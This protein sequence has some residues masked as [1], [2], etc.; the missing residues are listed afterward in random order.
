MRCGD[1]KLYVTV[2][3]YADGGMGEIFVNAHREGQEMRTMLGALA[4]MISQALQH[5]RD[6]AKIAEALNSFPYSPYLTIISF[7]LNNPHF[8][9]VREGGETIV[10]DRH[11][12]VQ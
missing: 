4:V 10:L 12:K 11:G 6:R 9:D 8:N 5:G 1:A 2:G 3:Y 7:I